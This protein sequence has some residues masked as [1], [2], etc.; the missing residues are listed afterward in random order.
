MEASTQQPP[1]QPEPAPAEPQGQP[2]TG[3]G[4]DAPDL[5]GEIQALNAKFDAQFGGEEQQP[6]PDGGAIY[7]NLAGIQPEGEPEFDPN[8]PQYAEYDEQDPQQGYDPA[9]FDPALY[10]QAQVDP[11]LNDRLA[12]LEQQTQLVTQELTARNIQER[13]SALDK[14]ATDM[15]QLQDQNFQAQVRDALAPV[16]ARYDN[17]NV[18]TDPV[19]VQWAA[20]NLIA[21]EEAASAT[22][23]EEAATGGAVLET[24][25]GPGNQG[26]D[27]SYSEQK[28]QQIVDAGT[29]KT[30]FTGGG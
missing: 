12:Q 16:A 8:D 20:Q 22:P 7:D 3:S 28:A 15:P 29:P 19:M 11:V 30:A 1:A 6:A 23:A 27:R 5:A 2:D 14:L 13:V 24:G 10:G 4:D 26:E 21:A 17:E 18:F 9:A 25:A